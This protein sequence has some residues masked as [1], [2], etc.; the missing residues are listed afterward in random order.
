MDAAPEDAL[1]ASRERTQLYSEELGIDL[2]A[3]DD[4]EYFKWFLASVLFGGRIT[5]TIPLLAG[6]TALDGR[7]AAYVCRDYVCKAPTDDPA[8]LRKQLTR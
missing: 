3:G 5:E 8:V 7:P 6:K 1:P 4:R 2:S